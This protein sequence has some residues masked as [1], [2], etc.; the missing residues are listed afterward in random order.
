MV[1]LLIVFRCQDVCFICEA[2][3]LFSP[4]R[5]L[6]L[7]GNRTSKTVMISDLPPAWLYVY[8]K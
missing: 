1:I 4:V 2:I 6:K 3:I 5:F 7:C 8:E